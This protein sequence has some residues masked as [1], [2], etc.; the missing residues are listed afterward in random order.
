MNKG[1]GVLQ[2]A[3]SKSAD[4]STKTAEKQDNESSGQAKFYESMTSFIEV[5]KEREAAGS[6]LKW[7]RKAPVIKAETPKAFMAEIIDLERLFSELGFK[8]QRKRWGVFRNAYK[9][10]RRRS[11][12]M[13]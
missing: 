2:I 13:I 11:S 9:E 1:E 4:T 6:I 3:D 8:T 7:D 5:M 12:N 10:R